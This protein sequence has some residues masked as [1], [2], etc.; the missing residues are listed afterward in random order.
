MQVVRIPYT[1]SLD[2]CVGK[3]VALQDCEAW[4]AR[5]AVSGLPF[6]LSGWNGDFEQSNEISTFIRDGK[7]C[8]EYP[9]YVRRN[10]WYRWWLPYPI[11]GA[12]IAFVQ[13]AWRLFRCD[14]QTPE[15]LPEIRK[16]GHDQNT[17][18]GAWEPGPG[19]AV[20]ISK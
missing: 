13:G 18:W 11:A 19:V 4:P 8:I 20:A 1:H 14:G 15:G 7:D 2:Q 9:V 5:L 10:H 6:F 3:Y 17:P 16:I 12:Y